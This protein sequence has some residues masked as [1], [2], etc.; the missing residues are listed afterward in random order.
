[1]AD[2]TDYTKLDELWP[3]RTF[4]QQGKKNPDG[5]YHYNRPRKLPDRTGSHT[6][7]KIVIHT[8]EQKPDPTPPDHGAEW[9]VKY[10][11]NTKRNASWHVSVDADSVQWA[12]PESYRAWHCHDISQS[13]L[14]VE[15]CLH[16][17]D[18]GK[19]D[20][21]YELDVLATAATVVGFWCQ[22]LEIPVNYITGTEARNAQG[23]ITMHGWVDPG[24][25]SDPGVSG[26]NKFTTF[27]HKLFLDLVSDFCTAWHDWDDKE[28]LPARGAQHSYHQQM[29]LIKNQEAAVDSTPDKKLQAQ[30]DNVSHVLDRGKQMDTFVRS[31]LG[32]EAWSHV[33][34]PA[35]I[36][37]VQTLVGSRA[38]GIVGPKT[39]AAVRRWL[40]G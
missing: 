11:L 16:A 25:R 29:L 40:N 37:M 9:L 30:L 5:Q 18:W 19:I 35:I 39:R 32:S 2:R 4:A 33:G 24:R 8:S 6:V 15:L 14:G 31:Y 28:H 12:L 3:G 38:D 7:N 34:N 36:K 21:R 13:S 27:P 20:P 17:K 26:T 10:Q 23:G 22:A 1:M